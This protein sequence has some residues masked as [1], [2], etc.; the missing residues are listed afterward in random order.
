MERHRSDDVSGLGVPGGRE[1]DLPSQLQL[2]FRGRYLHVTWR[3][4]IHPLRGDQ[5]D[6]EKY[7]VSHRDLRRNRWEGLKGLEE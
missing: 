4:S 5:E 2:D 7:E 1:L 3:L 6:R